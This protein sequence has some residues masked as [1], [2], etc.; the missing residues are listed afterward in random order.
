MSTQLSTFT[1]LGLIDA[2]ASAG[3]ITLPLSTQIPGRVLTFKDIYGAVAN[4][5]IVITTS[6]PDVFEDGTTY[7]TLTNPYDFLTVYTG[8]TGAWHV[9]GGNQFNWLRT[10]NQS[11]TGTSYFNNIST[12]NF[13]A[14]S[15]ISTLIVNS[16]NITG[17]NISSISYVATPNIFTTST[18]TSN[19]THQLG[20]VG[21]IFT[22]A[23]I[24][25]AY[26]TNR[27]STI[28][29][30]TSTNRWYQTWSLSTIASTIITDNAIVNN[31]VGGPF[32]LGATTTTNIYPYS[33]G[34]LVGYG[35]TTASN[36]F[37][38]EGHFRSTFTQ[39][40]QPT[41]DAGIFS[42]VVQINGYVSSQNIN[43][44][45]INQKMPPFWST[46]NIPPSTFNITGAS[47]TT[48]IILYSNVQFPTYT[49][50]MYKIHQKAIYTKASGN[51]FAD[52]HG[53]IFYTEGIFP[54]TPAILHDA[55]T[56]LPFVNQTGFSSFTTL[57]TFCVVSSITT[58]NISYYDSTS[59]AYTAN[60]YMGRL[61]IEYIP[62]FGINGDIGQ[63]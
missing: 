39:V 21:I 3:A 18:L 12:N 27:I 29:L 24:S 37:Y 10:V 26:S 57:T 38:S 2:R 48:P 47:A 13:Y 61:A 43:L 17:T 42:N 45:S 51:A 20:A 9:V 56:N 35:A 59:N 41:L 53:N 46:L 52:L 63:F 15:N 49:K 30:G 32:L 33:A 4:S 54:S 50:G 44:S 16:S 62:S 8:S 25:P 28:S 7:R 31:L 6:S 5:T 60:L 58:R 11:N 19:I 36:G 22:G 40:I 55:Y 23:S 34:S 1:E 14:L